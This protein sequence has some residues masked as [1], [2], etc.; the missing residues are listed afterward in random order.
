M[1]QPVLFR[2]KF[3]LTRRITPRRSQP[4]AYLS[5]EGGCR[6]SIRS[7][8]IVDSTEVESEGWG[9]VPQKAVCR[10]REGD[11]NREGRTNLG[12]CCTTNHTRL[13]GHYLTIGD[14]R[15][16]PA[17]LCVEGPSGQ[18]TSERRRIALLSHESDEATLPPVDVCV[19]DTLPRRQAVVAESCNERRPQL[20]V[21]ATS[22]KHS[23]RKAL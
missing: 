14:T 17:P 18:C 2:P 22:R 3:L 13:L 12:W 1:E 11:M 9:Y 15:Q 19:G 20:Q 10:I 21:D 4:S 5:R 6:Q 8:P 16:A 23:V 7:R